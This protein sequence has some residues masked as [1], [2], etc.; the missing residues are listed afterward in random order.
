[1][2]VQTDCSQE[3]SPPASDDPKHVAVTESEALAKFSTKLIKGLYDD[4]KNNRACAHS[5][6]H[7]IDYDDKLTLVAFDPCTPEEEVRNT[8]LPAMACR[9]KRL[10]FQQ[11]SWYVP[12][13]KTQAYCDAG[14]PDLSTWPDAGTLFMLRC[15]CP[16]GGIETM[17]KVTQAE[18]GTKTFAGPPELNIYGAA[19]GM[20]F[21]RHNAEAMPTH[22]M[23]TSVKNAKAKID[24]LMAQARESLDVGY[25]ES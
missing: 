15:E 25:S 11:E 20:F 23:T 13:D 16:Y 18:D 19:R 24:D 4:L 21:Y 8:L 1:M 5:I 10:G 6:A 2:Q 22:G 14:C 9:Y 7:A 3:G 17:I 12:P